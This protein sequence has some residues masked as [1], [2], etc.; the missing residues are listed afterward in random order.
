MKLSGTPGNTYADINLGVKEDSWKDA[1]NYLKAN[2]IRS[3]DGGYRAVTEDELVEM[4][5]C[6]HVKNF[7]EYK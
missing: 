1:H 7:L 4:R 2:S 3:Y 6:S 5:I